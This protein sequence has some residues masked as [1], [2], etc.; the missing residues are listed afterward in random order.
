MRIFHNSTLYDE[1]SRSVRDIVANEVSQGIFGYQ[2]VIGNLG[3]WKLRGADR[4]QMFGGGILTG[5]I[6]KGAK[7][8]IFDD[9]YQDYGDAVNAGYNDLIVQKYK[10]VYSQRLEQGGKTLHFGTLFAKTDFQLSQNCD[11]IFTL[12]ALNENGETISPHWRS[13]DEVLQFRSE[14]GDD[15]FNAM[16]MQNPTAE[17]IINPFSLSDFVR[18]DIDP[19]KCDY[20][21]TVTDPSFGCGSDYFCIIFGGIFKGQRYIFEIHSNNRLQPSQYFGILEQ[22]NEKTD[23][24]CLHYIEGNGVGSI[25]HA[26]A[27]DTRLHIYKFTSKNEKFSRIFANSED[28]KRMYFSEN[29]SSDHLQQVALYPNAPHDDIPDTL[30]HFVNQTARYI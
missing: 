15:L 5:V 3:Q 12:P 1:H 9:V 24:K 28:I 29:I 13:T 11:W 17:G 4:S 8:S 16:F 22:I 20:L 10:S 21:F 27:I 14:M 23:G 2:K 7:I 6:G 25:I 19:R 18:G 30:S 26:K